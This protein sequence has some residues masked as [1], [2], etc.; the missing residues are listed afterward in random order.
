MHDDACRLVDD[1]EVLVRVGDRELG[2]RDGR[3]RGRR[4]RRLDRDLLPTGE[5]VTLPL[6]PA[7][8]EHGAGVEQSLGRRPGA[9][10]REPGEVAVEPF[11]GAL[12]R[13]DDPVQCFGD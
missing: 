10:L 13:D 8:H 3:L 6:D 2:S 7:V 9:D 12:G 1:E 5:L 4:R 11:S